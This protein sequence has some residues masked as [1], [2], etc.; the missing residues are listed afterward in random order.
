M[1]LGVRGTSRVPT[2]LQ[3]QDAVDAAQ[4]G[5]ADI[6]DCKMPQAS[7]GTFHCVCMPLMD[8]L[9]QLRVELTRFDAHMVSVE[10]PSP[11]SS[12][13]AAEGHFKL[14]CDVGSKGWLTWQLSPLL[15]YA[16]MAV[17]SL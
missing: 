12:C 16:F 10:T 4:R 17:S 8:W 11:A 13:V 2:Q 7:T 15:G 14:T 9:P 6:L 5:G 1:A 3:H